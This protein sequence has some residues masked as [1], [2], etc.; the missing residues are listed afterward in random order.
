[1]TS[2]AA[3]YLVF[4][5]L[6]GRVLP[7]FRLAQAWQREHGLTL[8]GLLQVGD[9]GFFPDVHRLDRA[10]LRH[11]ED[12]PLELGV[13]LVSSPGDE[14]D[15][16]FYGEE[17]AP[18]A[19]WFTAGNHED[20]EILH[21]LATA[22]GRRANSFPVD[23]YLR[24]RCIRDGQVETLP[25]SLRVGALWGIDA[26]A[27]PRTPHLA[28]IQARSATVLSCSSFDV[29]LS[30]DSPSDAVYPSSGS[31]EIRDI[32]HIVRPAF[33]FFGHYSGQGKR[34]A[35]DFGT[36]QVFHLGGFE[37]RAHGGRAEA[38]SVGVLTWYGERGDFAYLDSA[39]LRTFTRHNWKYR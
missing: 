33:A 6:H 3:T 17:P 32:L 35:G 8:A 22:A 28:R 27:R 4:G 18:A 10:T 1:M 36:T 20:H 14:A 19:L 11:A 13:Q 7:A 5:D 21:T 12:D 2:P 39:W 30:H 26:I 31:A 34:I 16:I 23:H 38:G 9:L 15:A 24:V 29:L 37:M 25:G